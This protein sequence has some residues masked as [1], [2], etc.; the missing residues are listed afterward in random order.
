MPYAANQL[1]GERLVGVLVFVLFHFMDQL[2][3]SR[4]GDGRAGEVELRHRALM[5]IAE[6]QLVAFLERVA[7]HFG[8][9]PFS[10][11]VNEVRAFDDDPFS[12][13]A[14]CGLAAEVG[15]HVVRGNAFEE[16]FGVVQSVRL[17]Q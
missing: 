5:G 16:Y 17:S 10:E 12:G 1:S 8:V 6:D 7:H 15:D 11:L 13:D 14:E 9:L 3:E 2:H 4:N